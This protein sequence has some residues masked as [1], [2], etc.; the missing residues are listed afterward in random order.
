[1]TGT[2]LLPS[3]S[4]AALVEPAVAA[5]QRWPDA[6]DSSSRDRALLTLPVPPGPPAR[7]AA[8]D[9]AVPPGAVPD[10]PAVPAHGAVP[11]DGAV[12]EGAVPEGAVP[13]GAVPEG[14]VPDEG[15]VPEEDCP[16]R[17]PVRE[18]GNG[19]GQD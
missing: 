9:P 19:P 16:A 18:P 4:E 6:P 8:P 11:E 3:S 12:P 15:A 10:F 13:E 17:A 7:A 5:A 1:M 2:P 14:A